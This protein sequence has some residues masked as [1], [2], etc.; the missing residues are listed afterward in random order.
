MEHDSSYAYLG[1]PLLLQLDDTKPADTVARPRSAAWGP[2][3][4][5]IS[6]A[7]SVTPE[8]R[9]K[10]GV[11]VTSTLLMHRFQHTIP[12]QFEVHTDLA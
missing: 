3:S 9:Y 7:D 8:A 12:E 4:K 6:T 5:P 11:V 10:V 1:M 2:Y